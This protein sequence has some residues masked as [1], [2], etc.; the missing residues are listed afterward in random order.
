MIQLRRIT[1]PGDKDLQ[2]LMQLYE[3]AFPETERRNLEQLKHLVADKKEMIFNAIE[4][5]G[6]LA[7]FFV[8]WD[9]TDFYYL[10]YLAVYPEMR[11]QKIG[12]Q[13]LQ[14][15]AEHLKGIR[16]LEVEPPVDEMTTRR[17][18]YYRRNGYEVVD[19]G[20][21]QPSYD[22]RKPGLPL[23]I[24]CND[25]ETDSAGPVRTIQEEVYIKNY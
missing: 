14:Y 7:G 21:Y 5:E 20:Y 3:E 17:V 23:W 4:S 22:G 2:Q 12:Q 18:N 8:Y 15:V 24:M 11:N 19:K 1:D 10:E 16:F 6:V 9:F 13:L 25:K